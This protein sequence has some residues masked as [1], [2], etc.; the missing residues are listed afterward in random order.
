MPNQ[1]RFSRILLKISGEAFAAP[2]GFGLERAAFD[3]VAAEIADVARLGVQVAVV[4]GGGNFFRGARFAEELGLNRATADYMGMLGTVLNAIALQ[5]ALA[6]AGRETR[7]LSALAVQRVAEMFDRHKALRWLEQGRVVILAAGTGNPHVTTDSCAALRAVE[8]E[9]NVL[10]KA[11]KVDGV[12]DD[13][14]ARNPHAKRFDTV[15]YDQVIDGRLRVMDIAATDICQ[16]YAMPVIVFNFFD[17]GAMRRLA[18]GERLGTYM[19]PAAGP[20]P[21]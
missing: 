6:R 13:D 11:T 3:R 5:E 17:A 21:R 18:L 8:L 1:P 16:Q 7:V 10:L 14:P 15:T 19:G 9:A 2:G 12:Y 20:G 4:P